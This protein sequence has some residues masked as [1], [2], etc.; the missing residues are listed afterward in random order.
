MYAEVSK[1]YDMITSSIYELAKKE[2]EIQ[3][4]C[5]I[6]TQNVKAVA[7]VCDKCLVKTE[8]TLNSRACC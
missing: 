8:K 5:V 1:I 3:A 4:S 6:K 7:T 2:K